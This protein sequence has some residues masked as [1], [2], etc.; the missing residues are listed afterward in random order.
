MVVLE[1]LMV[2]QDWV[3]PCWALVYAILADYVMVL[4]HVVYA[5]GVQMVLQRLVA[6]GPEVM[7][8]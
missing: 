3:L 7:V 4:Q 5:V 1:A 2:L 6:Y 8:L